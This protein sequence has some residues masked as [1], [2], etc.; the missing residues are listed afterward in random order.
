MME[1]FAT[2]YFRRIRIVCKSKLNGKNKINALN[3]WAI[4]LMR[5]GAGILDW[6]V[7]ELDQVDRQI[8]KILTINK[9]FHPKSDIDRLYVSA[10]KTV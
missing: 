5:Y 1:A 4:S 10:A 7:N 8:R 3:T 6:R 9:E 2:E